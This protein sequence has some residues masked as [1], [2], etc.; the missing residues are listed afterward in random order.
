MINIYTLPAVPVEGRETSIGVS[1]NDT[2]LREWL[3]CARRRRLIAP[4]FF[5]YAEHP[6]DDEYNS[7]GTFRP[8]YDL[9][10]IYVWVDLLSARY[11]EVSYP[12]DKFWRM[13]AKNT[14]PS[15]GLCVTVTVD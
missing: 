7:L 4:F 10:G 15:L 13:L 2:K 3:S 11:R 14:R 8:G 9:G 6:G 5:L 12:I 1:L